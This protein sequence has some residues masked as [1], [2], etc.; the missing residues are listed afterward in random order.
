MEASVIAAAVFEDAI[1]RLG[2]TH[3]I[4]DATKLDHTI[5]ALKSRGIFTSIEAKRLRYVAGL[6]NSAL[7][8]SWDEFDISDVGNLIDGVEHLLGYIARRSRP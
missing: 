3:S 8:A 7:H 4:G 1:K 6:R 5:S 2:E